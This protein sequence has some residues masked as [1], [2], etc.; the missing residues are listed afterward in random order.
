[1]HNVQNAA[2]FRLSLSHTHVPMLHN[3]GRLG[4]VDHDTVDVTNLHRQVCGIQGQTSVHAH[5]CL[6]AS[7]LTT[8][9]ALAALWAT[10]LCLLAPST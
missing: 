5:A 7:A 1:M 9:A 2:V 6:V 4:L 3:A 8:C 10:A